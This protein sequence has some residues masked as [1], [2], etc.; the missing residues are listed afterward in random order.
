MFDAFL[1]GSNLSSLENRNLI[2]NYYNRIYT[3]LYGVF[4]REQMIEC[5]ISSSNSFNRKSAM[6]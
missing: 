3:V 5:S 4:A 2:F 1:L 6:L